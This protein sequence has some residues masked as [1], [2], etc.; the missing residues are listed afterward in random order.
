MVALTDIDGV[1]DGEVELEAGMLR[2]TLPVA[3]DDVV[4]DAVTEELRLNEALLDAV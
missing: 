3:D 4:S 2:V 1:I